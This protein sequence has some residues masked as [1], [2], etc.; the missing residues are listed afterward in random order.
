MK[1]SFIRASMVMLIALSVPSRLL[2][3]APVT[4][5]WPNN[6]GM[7]IMTPSGWGASSGMVFL[8]AGITSPQVYS[9]NDDTAVVAGIG[10]GNPSKNLG[11]ELSA[12]MNDV[13][14][15]S[16]FSYGIK[17]SR[18]VG[19][20]TSVA[21][22]GENLF[23]DKSKN[24]ADESCYIVVS[25]AVQG[26]SSESSAGSSKL[27]L[28]LGV[29]KGRFSD[30]S[31][32]DIAA[33][34]GEH[35]TRVFGSVACELFKATNVVVEWSGINLNAGISTGLLSLNDHVFVNLTVAAGDLT[36]YSADG[37]R[38]LGSMSVAVLL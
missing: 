27:N 35:G 5:L 6:G 21:V 20:G 8:G 30:M 36:G 14:Q 12:V 18:I 33:G 19:D 26:L 29:G 10:I 9:D 25:H 38:L 15:R 28:T 13:S 1:S 37:V 34:K 24:D 4:P 22:G 16:N 17:L 31:P 3:V 2:A 23:R 7:T 32:D 11:I